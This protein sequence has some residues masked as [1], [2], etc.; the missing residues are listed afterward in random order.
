MANQTNHTNELEENL[1][2]EKLSFPDDVFAP[3]LE[4]ERENFHSTLESINVF[5]DRKKAQLKKEGNEYLVKLQHGYNVIIQTIASK[6][7][8]NQ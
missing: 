6:S 8:A 2:I 7:S 5:L 4:A 1:I 3:I